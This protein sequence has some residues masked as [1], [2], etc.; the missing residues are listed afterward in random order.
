MAKEQ[1]GNGPNCGPRF[2]F[3][4]LKICHLTIFQPAY[5]GNS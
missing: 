3:G 2:V 5:T 1:M 4:H